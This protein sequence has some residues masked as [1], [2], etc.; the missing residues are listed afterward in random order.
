MDN[1]ARRLGYVRGRYGLSMLETVERV[2]AAFRDGTA[3]ALLT[4]AQRGR[5]RRKRG[6][7]HVNEHPP[8]RKGPPVL[9]IDEA[10][11]MRPVV[12]DGTRVSDLVRLVRE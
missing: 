8:A 5:V 9:F 7:P 1:Y 2:Q 10:R 4:P 3:D 11:K 6:G 12:I